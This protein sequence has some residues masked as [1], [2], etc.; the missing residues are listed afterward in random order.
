MIELERFFR[1][2]M[3]FRHLRLLVAMDDYRSAK[4]V[5]AYLNITQPAVSKTLTALETGL[6]IK[7]FHRTQRGMEPTMLGASLIRHSR[8]I[9]AQLND[10]QD[11]LMD[12]NRNRVGKIALGVL[13]TAS[14]VVMPRF[15]TRIESAASSTNIRI[16]EGTMD[17]LLPSLR[18]G[19]V[20]AVVGLLPQV[21]M[22][23]EFSSQLL[24]EDPLV[25]AVRRGHPLE[26]VGKVHWE[27]VAQFPLILPPSNATTRAAIDSI[28]LSE[29]VATPP[30]RVETVSTMT[31]IGVLQFSDTVALM[32]HSLARH[33]EKLGQVSI[34]PLRLPGVVLRLGLIW[35]TDRR[36][37]ETFEQVR[38]V[39]EEVCSELVS[40]EA[41]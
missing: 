35:L 23:A 9:L 21:P 17:T 40:T 16:S 37:T 11:E 6:G 14:V 19:D 7:L 25:V 34:L 36:Y 30:R 32:S 28:L 24:I 15:V 27:D 4:R 31:T 26:R 8:Q 38:A 33:F 5:A 18:A 2:N 41:H 10:A 1:G 13:P 29:N 39:F 12:I 3:N 22:P 20:D